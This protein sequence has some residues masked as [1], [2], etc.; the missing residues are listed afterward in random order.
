MAQSD[1]CLTGDQE[2]AVMEI[3]HEIFSMVILPLLLIQA[4][5]LSVLGERICAQ[6]WL[7]TERTM[8]VQEKY[9]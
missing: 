4:R 2:V 6:Y 1:E 7:T 5:Q 9:G 3:N 8:P